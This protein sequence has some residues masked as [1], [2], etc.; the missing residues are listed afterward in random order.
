LLEAQQRSA[1][2]FRALVGGDDDGE[3]QS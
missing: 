1:E 2:H 3:L